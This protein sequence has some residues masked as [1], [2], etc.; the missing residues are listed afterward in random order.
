MKEKMQRF[1]TGRYGFD[2]LSKVS[3][4]VTLALMVV[5]IF[6]R[7]T[8]IYLIALV[9]LV[10]VY[11][12]AFSRNITKRQQ[13]NQKFLNMRYQAA[14]RRE[15]AKQKREQKKIYRFYKCPSCKQKVRVPRGKGKICITCP[16]CS[17]EFIR[18]S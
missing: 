2:E 3:L 5:S 4:Y 1:M 6:S 16:K 18:K 12:R 7:N 9:S 15:Q 17:Q 11:V 10:F 14:V 13:E 8:L